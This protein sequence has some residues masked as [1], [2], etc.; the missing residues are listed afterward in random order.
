MDRITEK[1]SDGTP[2]IPNGKIQMIGMG[3]IAKVLSEYEDKEELE[4]LLRIPCKEELIKN[5]KSYAEAYRLPPYGREIEGTPELLEQA[6][7]ELQNVV[8]TL[9]KIKK[10]IREE[11]NYPVS[12][13][14]TNPHPNEQDYNKVHAE[15]FNRIWNV[16]SDVESQNTVN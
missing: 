1:Y 16:I 10:I 12:N 15:K 8:T 2:F 5:L 3:G 9:E 7:T 14:L 6:A 11:E 4:L 13:S